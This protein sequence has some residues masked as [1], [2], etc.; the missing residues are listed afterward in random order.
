VGLDFL[1]KFVFGRRFEQVYEDFLHKRTQ[2]VYDGFDSDLDRRI[3][4]YD[5][6]VWFSLFSICLSGVLV[7]AG[8]VSSLFEL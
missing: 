6:G 3:R 4:D 7:S 2:A 8:L 1:P 5:R